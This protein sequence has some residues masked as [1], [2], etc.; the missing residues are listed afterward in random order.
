MQPGEGPSVLESLHFSGDY[1]VVITGRKPGTM[2][3]SL[4]ASSY[5][6]YMQR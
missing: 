6:I 5:V 3:A 4:W 1:N 2:P